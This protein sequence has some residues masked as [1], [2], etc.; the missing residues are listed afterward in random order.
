MGLERNKLMAEREAERVANDVLPEKYQGKPLEELD[1]KL[2][3]KWKEK[4]QEALAETRNKDYSGLTALTEEE[5]VA[6]AEGKA[7]LMVDAF[8]KKEDYAKDDKVNKLW[9]KVNKATKATLQ[10]TY[11]GGI[12]DADTYRQTAEMYEYYIP[13][14]GWDTDIASDVYT[15]LT[16]SRP[17]LSPAM[18]IA[19]GRSSLADDPIAT[20]G[21]M[22]ES[23]IAQ[24]NRNAMKRAFYFFALNNPSDLVTIGKQWYIKNEVT[25]LPKTCPCF[26]FLIIDYIKI[27][28]NSH[29]QAKN[30]LLYH[31]VTKILTIFAVDFA[32]FHA[33]ITILN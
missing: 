7:Q 15:Y 30:S 8:E 17:M 16:S 5:D 33:N 20:I 24:A 13:L 3:N 29:L 23:T 6:T 9:E 28:T 32:I 4:Y 11:E 21:L 18:K 26:H 10:K 19:H 22:A 31:K 1:L 27:T 2:Q 12:I 14:R 25:F